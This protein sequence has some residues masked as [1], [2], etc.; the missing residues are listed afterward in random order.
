MGRDAPWGKTCPPPCNSQ[1]QQKS[2][3]PLAAAILDQLQ[4]S[5][6]STFL[7]SFHQNN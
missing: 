7:K 1:Q 2:T 4:M 6:V 3:V 5:S